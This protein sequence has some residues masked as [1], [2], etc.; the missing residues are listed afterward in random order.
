MVSTVVFHTASDSSDLFIR[1]S[2]GSVLREVL[3]A[4][5]AS[6]VAKDSNIKKYKH[7]GMKTESG[8]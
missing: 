2:V 7:G 6:N 1:F 4:C 3:Y 5:Y 8:V